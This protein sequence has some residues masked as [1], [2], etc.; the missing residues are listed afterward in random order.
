MQ[1]IELSGGNASGV[2]VRVGASV[3]KPASASTPVVMRYMEFLRRRGVPVPAHYGFDELG[4][5]NLEYIDGTLAMDCTEFGGPELR[6]AGAM[7]REIHDASAEFRWKQSDQFCTPIAA[8]D[9]QLMCHNDLA[10]WNL[11][12]GDQWVFI[13]WDSTAPS[14][15]LWD[16]A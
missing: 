3:R 11:M 1:E 4:R 13:D 15:R 2:V 5:Q 7:V 12:L 8:P 16:L 6:R 10:P 14:T 9:Q